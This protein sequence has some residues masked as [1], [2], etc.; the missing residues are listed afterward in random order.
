MLMIFTGWNNDLYR[1]ILL[2]QMASLSHKL[3]VAVVGASVLFHIAYYSA[4]FL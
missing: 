3:L 1:I 4:T 2:L